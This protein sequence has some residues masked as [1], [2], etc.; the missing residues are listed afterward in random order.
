MGKAHTLNTTFDTIAEVIDTPILA[1][2]VLDYLLSHDHY[3]VRIG[4]LRLPGIT[5]QHLEDVFAGKYTDKP[6]SEE[7]QVAARHPAISQERLRVCLMSDNIE[8][9]AAAAENPSLMTELIR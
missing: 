1:A 9:A 7:L 8:L 2:G 6:T 5:M 3:L 4:A